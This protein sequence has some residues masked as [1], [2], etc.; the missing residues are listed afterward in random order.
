MRG[1]RELL[2]EDPAWPELEVA[3]RAS[4]RVTILPRHA[5]A[6][7]AC[8]EKLQVTTRSTLGALAHE[9]GGMLVD[10]GWLRLF[11]CGHE[12][13]RRALG[14][15]NET[16]GI[17]LADF[18]LVADDVVGGA[19]A[20]NGGALGATLGNIYY[21]APDAL[22]WED[23]ELGNSAFVQWALKGDL[24]AFYE[25]MR[26]SG[27]QTDIDHVGGDQTLS[28]YPPPWTKEGKDLSKVSRRAV[29][30]HEVWGLQQDFARQLQSPT[31][32]R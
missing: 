19:F 8:L 16:L 3:A 13:L 12:R 26:W 2:S 15:W 28:L 6:A 27:W 11:G 4:G 25:G 17:P 20:I 30:A 32:A 18:L 24:A 1:Y 14:Q 9:T 29:P 22:A 21:F 23:M 31:S 10:H 7:R 5:D